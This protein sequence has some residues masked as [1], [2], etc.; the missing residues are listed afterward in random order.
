LTKAAQDMQ[1]VANPIA[2][3]AEIHTGT[4]STTNSPTRID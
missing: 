2:P 1:L 3:I 4:A